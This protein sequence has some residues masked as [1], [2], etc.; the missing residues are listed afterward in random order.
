MTAE[1]NNL[2]SIFTAYSAYLKVQNPDK[3]Y[4]DANIKSAL[5]RYTLPGWG[6]TVEKG[7]DPVKLMAQVPIHQFKD[8]LATQEGVFESL[9]KEVSGQTKRTYRMHLKQMLNW[10]SKQRWWKENFIGD[11]PK[12]APRMLVRKGSAK[13]IRVTTKPKKGNY[14]LT[15]CQMNETLKSEFSQLYRFLTSISIRNRKEEPVTEATAKSINISLKQ[16]LGWIHNIRNTPLEELSLKL[17]DD[18]DLIDEYLDWYRTERQAAPSSESVQI[19]SFLALARFHHYKTSTAKFYRDIPIIEQLRELLNNTEKRAKKHS[20]ISDDSKKW[21]DWSEYLAAVEQLKQECALRRE[22]GGLRPQTAVASSYQ[23]YLIAAFLAYMPPDRQR[24]LR[25]LEIGR[26]LVK[27][28]NN[29]FIKLGANDYKTGKSYGEQITPIPDILYHEI[30]LWINKW[31]L[32]FKPNHNFFF[33][34]TKGE[35]MDGASIYDVFIGAMYRVTGKRTNPHLIRS[36]CITHFQRTGATDKDME[37]LAL[38]MKHSREMQREVYDKRTQQ[39]KVQ[40]ALNMMLR[41][42]AGTLPSPPKLE[43]VKLDAINE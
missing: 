38:A 8:A 3:P 20:K 35:P 21:L 25:E 40:P 33:T 2:G 19:R 1:F 12:Y 18:I 10:C 31:R 17:L 29:W 7:Q 4:C 42:K 39:E 37:A 30:E 5:V 28:G 13:D 15:D 26:T 36:M 34:K 27:D 43:P 22:S 41:Q 6:L 16:I 14:G 24:T 11:M 9:G 23:R 32:V